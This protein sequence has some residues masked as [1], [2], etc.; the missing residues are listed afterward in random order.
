M[1]IQ[2]ILCGENIIRD[3]ENGQVTV[4]NLLD[5]ISASSYP[6]LIPK[7]AIYF[8][9]ERDSKEDEVQ[10]INLKIFNNES[11]LFHDQ[12]QINFNGKLRN[13]AVIKFNG[14]AV[15][16]DGLLIIRV[17]N[18]KDEVLNECKIILTLISK[19][20]EVSTQ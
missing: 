18:L 20:P 17:S 1:N 15:P 10:K 14:L 5:D 7:F 12:I 3:S 13:R 8:F 6:L 9:V 19:T 4:Y 11:P 2:Q 16:S